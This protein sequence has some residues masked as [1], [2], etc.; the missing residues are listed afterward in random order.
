MT[1]PQ[2]A[3]RGVVSDKVKDED[4][5][6]ATVAEINRCCQGHVDDFRSCSTCC[7]FSD[8]EYS[9]FDESDKDEEWEEYQQDYQEYSQSLKNLLE[10]TF[11][12]SLIKGNRR[13]R[14]RS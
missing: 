11:A 2:H 12:S 1:E 4:D 14:R 8:T 13:G 6:A 5:V 9:D 7:L 3:H 10:R